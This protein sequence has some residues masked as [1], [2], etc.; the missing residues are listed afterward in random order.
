[1]DAYAAAPHSFGFTTAMTWPQSSDSTGHVRI[2]ANGR[3]RLDPDASLRFAIAALAEHSRN[4]DVRSLTR[5]RTAIREVL[6]SRH[7]GLVPHWS[8]HLD[9]AG[10]PMPPGWVSAETQGLLLSALCRLYSATGNADWRSAADATFDTLL[11]VR[12]A[13][14]DAGHPYAIWTSFIDEFGFLWFEKYPHGTTATESMTGHLFAVLGIYDYAQISEGVR[15]R[16]AIALF[17]GGAA[18]GRHFLPSIRYENAAA[19]T[20][21]AKVARSWDLQQVLVAQMKALTRITRDAAYRAY[22]PVFR[23]DTAVNQFAT[24]GLTPRAGVDAYALRSV[25]EVL[26]PTSAIARTDP[27]RLLETALKYLAR[28][29]DQ[30][31]PALL[32]RATT[33]VNGV[34]Q[35]TRGGLVPH[36]LPA[37]NHSGQQ[38]V[39]P[40]YSAQTQGLTLSVLTRLAEATG[41]QRWSDAAGAVFATLQFS[42][43][44]RPYSAAEPRDIWTS[45]VGDDKTPTNLWFEKYYKQDGPSSYNYPSMIVDAHI[46]AVFGVYDYWR[47]TADPA[48]AQLFDGGASTLISRLPD[49]RRPGHASREALLSPGHR[50]NHHRVVTQ[51]LAILARMTGDARFAAYSHVFG[52]DAS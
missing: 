19:W 9:A 37:R 38:L 2:F 20:S 43:N 49:I 47:M 22:L 33:L 8:R 31:H 48:A 25:D 50:L 51:Q 28:D 40:W 32:R 42:R 4:G 44:T 35:H 14:D 36:N 34:M 10:R 11:R 6:A 23:H 21:P 12:G 17:E 24:T 46:T 39:T 15:H 29:G 41:E 45:F 26:P 5:A 13:T 1:V 3:A 27:D 16:S 18:T 52:K 30:H 7:E